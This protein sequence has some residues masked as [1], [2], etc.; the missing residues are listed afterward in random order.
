M[1]K[2]LSLITMV[3][4]S[5]SIVSGCT[6]KITTSKSSGTTIEKVDTQNKTVTNKKEVNK[7]TG[8]EIE[9]VQINEYAKSFKIT[10]LKDGYRLINIDETTLLTVP[11]GKEVPSNIEKDI[12]VIKTPIKRVIPLSTT[13]MAFM[14]ALGTTDRIIAMNKKPDDLGIKQLKKQV[15]EGKTEYIG[16]GENLDFE[17]I[18]ALKPDF[19]FM[20]TEGL[21]YQGKL[22]SKFTELAI[23]WTGMKI[24]VENDPRARIEWIKVFA[25]LLDKEKE[26][27][28]WFKKEKDRINKIEET[29]KSKNLDKK[30]MYFRVTSKGVTVR[31]NNDYTVKMTEVAGGINPLKDKITGESG[32]KT[33]SIEEFYTMA[34]EADILIHETMSEFIGT[35]E[36]LVN[37]LPV[38]KDIKAYKNDN[39]WVTSIDYWQHS[40]KMADMIEEINSILKDPSNKK[41]YEYYKHVK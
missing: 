41:D 15:D 38:L 3:I 20:V 29:N 19:A 37:K 8:L 18:A 1:K 34:S 17:K 16:S 22:A 35:K 5:I 9:K 23:P 12:K 40:E 13:D 6:A 10:E 31:V 32:T 25:S 2:I 24:H 39:I 30:I 14:N 27:E 4:V 21:S 33:L 7:E 11:E 36:T 28:E 26:G